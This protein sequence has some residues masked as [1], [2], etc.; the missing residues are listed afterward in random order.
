MSD[1]IDRTDPDLIHLLRLLALLPL[2]DNSDYWSGY[3][4]PYTAMEDGSDQSGYLCGRLGVHV[5]QIMDDGDKV[6]RRHVAQLASYTLMFFA[7][8]T[9]GQL[10]L[11]DR[12]APDLQVD[13]SAGIGRRWS[14]DAAATAWRLWVDCA[15]PGGGEVEERLAA[16][17][18]APRRCR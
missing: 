15:D 10:E 4:T 16:W 3:W 18:A 11:L 12:V 13:D 8:P 9:T 6:E 7:A 2:P 14:Q 5:K 17:T 1:V